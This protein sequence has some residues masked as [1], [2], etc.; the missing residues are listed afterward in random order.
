MHK[1]V[2]S[3]SEGKPS[4]KKRPHAL[5]KER[6]CSFNQRSARRGFGGRSGL[7][8]VEELEAVELYRRACVVRWSKGRD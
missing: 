3:G 8:V 5:P 7:H 2:D 6:G 4:A 1:H